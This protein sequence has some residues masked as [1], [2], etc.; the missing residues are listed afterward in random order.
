MGFAEM[1]FLGLLKIA[2]VEIADKFSTL[3]RSLLVMAALAVYVIARDFFA[4]AWTLHR[5]VDRE[6]RRPKGTCSL[7]PIPIGRLSAAG[8]PTTRTITSLRLSPEPRIA[9]K[10]GP[11]R[12]EETS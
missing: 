12:G 4:I 10:P 2:Q 8:H 11:R 5:S 1:G 7:F 6:N 9:C 3:Q